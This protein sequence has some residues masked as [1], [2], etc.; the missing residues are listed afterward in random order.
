M[1]CAGATLGEVYNGLDQHLNW[2]DRMGQGHWT[3]VSAVADVDHEFFFPVYW[4]ETGLIHEEIRL[5]HPQML[6]D[7][8]FDRYPA[9]RTTTL[10]A[11]TD[12]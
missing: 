2:L 11:S 5:R 7:S 9:T 8:Y 1:H 12:F 4:I 6:E 10:C 3:K